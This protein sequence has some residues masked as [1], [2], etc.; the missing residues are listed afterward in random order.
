[1]SDD[2]D[3]TTSNSLAKELEVTDADLKI[4]KNLE[5]NAE[6]TKVQTENPEEKLSRRQRRLKRKLLSETNP[7]DQDKN[8]LSEKL[9]KKEPEIAKLDE[10]GLTRKQRKNLRARE[11]RKNNNKTKDKDV[12]DKGEE[13]NVSKSVT[14][15][16]KNYNER[17]KEMRRQIQLE[18]Q[19][20]QF[21]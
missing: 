8:L 2:E 12:G 16:S 15:T 13:E 4:Y 14:E 3:W 11:R 1:M 17:R 6:K 9:A 7:L 18:S 5:Q 21:L 19:N 20:L 10:N